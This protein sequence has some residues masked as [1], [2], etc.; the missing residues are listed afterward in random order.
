MVTLAD[1]KLT[2][3]VGHQAGEGGSALLASVLLIT[4]ITGAGL[5][6]M[7][8]TSFSQNKAKN[9]LKDKQASYLAEAGLVHGKSVLNQ[10]IANWNTYAT[11]TTPH[12][13]VA[14]TALPGIGSYT[15]TIMGASATSQTGLVMTATGT[16][17]NADTNCNSGSACVSSLMAQGSPNTGTGSFAFRTG[18]DFTISGSPTIDGIGGGVQANRNLTISGN[19]HI[20]TE[21]AAV[22]TYTATGSPVAAFAGGGMP[23]VSINNINA[24][25]YYN[26]N[27]VDY[28]LWN[29]GTVLDQNFNQLSAG[30]TWNCWTPPSGGS[31]TWTLTCSTPPNGT[32]WVYGVAMLQSDAGT[33]AH[34]WIAT[35]V[36][37]YSIQVQST[38]LVMRSPATTDTAANGIS[39]G[40]NPATDC[41]KPLTQ[42]LLFIASLDLKII[43][44]DTQN[45]SGIARAYEQVEISG[46]PT[47]NGYIVAQ[48]SS[49]TNSRVTANVISGN[50]HLTY[51]GNLSV[52]QQSTAQV[53]AT[54]S[55]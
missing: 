27:A 54:L 3:K 16:P 13:L 48:D 45:F 5:A 30:G 44:T 55:H 47:F 49:S 34:P 53:Q 43:G 11:Y 2:R 52:S 24:M 9:L 37:Y 29:D 46:A 4:L 32:Y 20:Q 14:A 36:G 26:T 38:N 51:N 10:H 8:T 6:A 50:M 23:A 40:P 25:T 31:N 42:N 21:A 33:V 41:Y 7:T 22:G 17:N 28:Y 35:I 19:P 18:K 1:M 39:C 12:T 15:V